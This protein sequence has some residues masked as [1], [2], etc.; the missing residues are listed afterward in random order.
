MRAAEAVS[1]EARKLLTHLPPPLARAGVASSASLRAGSLD[2]Q[3]KPAP[4]LR[5]FNC[6]P[7]SSDEEVRLGHGTLAPSSDDAVVH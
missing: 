5:S 7:R 4:A 3:R 2:A 1:S 6:S